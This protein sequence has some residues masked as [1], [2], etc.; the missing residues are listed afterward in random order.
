MMSAPIYLTTLGIFFGT[1]LLVF[2]LRNLAV[3]QQARAR[4]ALEES[5]RQVAAQAAAAQVEIASALGSINQ[6]LADLK[7]RMAGVEKVL[8]VPRTECLRR[9]RLALT[10]NVAIK[11]RRQASV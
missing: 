7:A 10:A 9:A 5:H 6:T 11:P 8:R 1:V 2:G 4:L 3:M